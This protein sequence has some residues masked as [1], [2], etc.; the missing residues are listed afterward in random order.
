MPRLPLIILTLLLLI[1]VPASLV[2]AQPLDRESL[3]EI[4]PETPVPQ[5]PVSRGAFAAMLVE[6]AGLPLA[7]DSALPAGDVEPGSWYLPALSTLKQQGIVTGYADGT[8]RPA[9]PVTRVEAAVMVARTLGLT[10]TLYRPEVKSPLQPAHWGAIPYNWLID[11]GLLTGELDPAEQ[12]TVGEAADLLARVFGSDPRAMEVV[13]KNQQ[14]ATGAR[15]MAMEATIDLAVKPRADM[16]AQVPALKMSGQMEMKMI[17]PGT[18]YMNGRLRFE[19]V[20]S[21]NAGGELPAMEMEQYYVDGQLYMKVTD[22]ATGKAEWVKMSMP[23][24]EGMMREQMQMGAGGI[25]ED[26]LS[27][28]H[29]H[30]LGTTQK[31]GETVYELGYYG[32]IDDLAAFFQLYLPAS[33][34]S[35]LSGPEFEKALDAVARMVRSISLWGKDYIGTDDYLTRG[36]EA[37]V[38]VALNN[39]LGEESIP[40]ELVEMRVQVNRCDYGEVKI[41]L[42]AEAKEARELP[43]PGQDNILSGN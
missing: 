22:P 41:E 33:M 28:F 43:A 13:K 5:G 7:V 15:T 39:K 30:V 42:P 14:A 11:Q 23:E 8:L 36:G 35:Q 3:L 27:A 26:L 18:W 19:P 29:Y 38:V 6:A 32:R 2:F 40:V 16:A 4:F 37:F 21:G 24:L 1:L 20:N 10:G 25:P 34:R 31:N 12:V 17:L 9:Q